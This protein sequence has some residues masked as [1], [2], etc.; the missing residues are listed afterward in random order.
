MTE[1]FDQLGTRASVK[2]RQDSPGANA[3]VIASSLHSGSVDAMHRRS[4]ELMRQVVGRLPATDMS[5]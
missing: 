4:R 3:H 1:M 2:P 5:A